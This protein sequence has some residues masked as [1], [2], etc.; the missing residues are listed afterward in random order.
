VG[1]QTRGTRRGGKRGRDD[2]ADYEA[3]DGEQEGIAQSRR[4]G[5]GRRGRRA[6]PTLTVEGDG[7]CTIWVEAASSSRMEEQG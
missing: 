1:V 3:D 2:S 5:E 4:N 7:A 6:A